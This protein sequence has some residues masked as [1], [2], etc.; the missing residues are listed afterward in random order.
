MLGPMHAGERRPMSPTRN[1]LDWNT[2]APPF[3][4]PKRVP[5]QL[6][7][8]PLGR[9]PVLRVNHWTHVSQS[10]AQVWRPGLDRGERLVETM[11]G[12]SAGFDTAAQCGW[13]PAQLHEHMHAR[14]HR[15]HKKPRPPPPPP[16]P[17]DE[18]DLPA[19]QILR[20]G[21]EGGN[22]DFTEAIGTLELAIYVPVPLPWEQ[23]QPGQ[24][25]KG[26]SAGRHTAGFISTVRDLASR[27]PRADKEAS[28]VHSTIPL[29]RE[30]EYADCTADLVRRTEAIAIM[31]AAVTDDKP[32][33]KASKEVEGRPMVHQKSEME[34]G[35]DHIKEQITECVAK[36]ANI[37]ALFR[38]IDEDGEG[39]LDLKEF[40]HGLRAMG[41]TDVPKQYSQMLFIELAGEVGVISYE[42]FVRQFEPAAHERAMKQLGAVCSNNL[43]CILILKEPRKSED[44]LRA[45]LKEQKEALKMKQHENLATLLYN[46]IDTDGGGCIEAEEVAALSA[47]LGHPLTGTQLQE[48]MDDMDADRSGEVDLEEFQEWFSRGKEVDCAVTELNLSS[49]LLILH[50]PAE[51]LQASNHAVNRLIKCNAVAPK[52]KKKGARRKSGDVSLLRPGNGTTGSVCAVACLVQ[53]QAETKVAANYDKFSMAANTLKIAAGHAERWWDYSSPL[54]R[55]VIDVSAKLEQR[56]VRH[57]PESTPAGKL[58]TLPIPVSALQAI[59]RSRAQTPGPSFADRRAAARR[60]FSSRGGPRPEGYHGTSSSMSQSRSGSMRQSRSA[61]SLNYGGGASEDEADEMDVDFL[62]PKPVSALASLNAAF[63]P[64][65]FYQL[66]SDGE[67]ERRNAMSE[68][69]GSSI[70]WSPVAERGRVPET[71][72]RAG[73]GKGEQ[74]MVNE[75]WQKGDRLAA[76]GRARAAADGNLSRNVPVPSFQQK[77][78]LVSTTGAAKLVQAAQSRRN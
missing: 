33:S 29:L 65:D 64:G 6:S 73:M 58:R 21:E 53:G 57:L 9:E 54:A 28:A 63:H 75:E 66:D 27:A 8:Q 62:K 78:R 69:D 70:F 59:E 1:G 49:T 52:R 32:P 24:R 16:P 31:T 30:R 18:E 39:T 13:Q 12:K 2:N 51:A 68:S 34:I 22:L 72:E 56:L 23:V 42:A 38:E 36:Q 26:L 74:R 48:A 17:P 76:R 7:K 5:A 4:A 47:R 40:R 37:V 19:W 77:G 46:K 44:L 25:R 60:A 14:I 20:N 43:G 45:S 67:P 10:P 35:I 61:A 50:R 55:G 41:L 3:T 11:V 15:V 71:L